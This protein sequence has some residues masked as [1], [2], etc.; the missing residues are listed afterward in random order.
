MAIPQPPSDN[1]DMLSLYIIVYDTQTCKPVAIFD[2][3][4]AY[5]QFIAGLSTNENIVFDVLY[6]FS[7]SIFMDKIFVGLMFCAIKQ[8]TTLLAISELGRKY[9]DM[10][11][12]LQCKEYDKF[13]K[14]HRPTARCDTE[15]SILE[16]HK[17]FRF[18]TT[19]AYDTLEINKPNEI[20][21]LFV[22]ISTYLENPQVLLLTPNEARTTISVISG[23]CRFAKKFAYRGSVGAR[24]YM[25][26]KFLIIYSHC[27]ED[28]NYTI[29]Y[30][31]Q[32]ARLN[33]EPI[34]I[35]RNIAKDLMDK[36]IENIN[37]AGLDE[38]GKLALLEE[39]TEDYLARNHLFLGIQTLFP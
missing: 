22:V 13:M 11:T 17:N 18:Y 15:Q 31:E 24:K 19:F 5:T 12:N 2:D 32:I 25:M 37:Y 36:F 16:N 21:T 28:D 33:E 27:Q 26:E 29:E 1:E 14:K 35:Y 3:I 4:K 6:Y 20:T 23:T 38:A 30:V 7:D 8:E 9:L 39:K 34:Y 10:W